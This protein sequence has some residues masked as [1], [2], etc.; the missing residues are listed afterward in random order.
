M[1]DVDVS[2]IKVGDTAGLEV[3]EVQRDAGEVRV[4]SSAGPGAA[5]SV[6]VDLSAIVSHTPAPKPA[7]KVGDRVLSPAGSRWEVVFI[8]DG[9]HVHFGAVPGNCHFPT[10]LSEVETWERV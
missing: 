4:R 7:L 8:Q 5:C 10:P 9:E 6:W 2:K 3:V 1:N